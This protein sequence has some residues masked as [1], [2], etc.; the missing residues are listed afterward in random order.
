M[1]K[2]LEG[3]PLLTNHSKESETLKRILPLF[4]LTALLLSACG[5]KPI[6][7]T[8]EKANTHVSDLTEAKD[9]PAG[10]TKTLSGKYKIE[11][12]ENTFYVIT[13]DKL[14]LVESGT[15]SFDSDKITIQYG[16]NSPVT[17]QV[18]E[19]EKGFNLTVK[20]D[21]I[22]LP[23]EYMEGTDGLMSSKPFDGV[24][25]VVN[26]G[27]GYVFYKDGTIDVVTTHEAEVTKDSIS[28]GGLSY[29]WKAKDG[30]IL[31]YD[32]S[33]KKQKTPAITMVPVKE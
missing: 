15:Y 11:G 25:G 30:K 3:I 33:D 7:D 28:F 32:K 21:S 26:G 24:Y 31:F 9:A 22:L 18:E 5:Q 27:P 23:L 13:T 14:S 6:H 2:L 16:N 20:E 1:S 19:N 17:Y 8:T 4:L 29:T 10:D 12:T